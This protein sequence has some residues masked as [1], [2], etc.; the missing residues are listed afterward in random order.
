MRIEA[1]D[2]SRL[3]SGVL[4]GGTAFLRH[5]YK[6]GV[7][8]DKINSFKLFIMGYLDSLWSVGV[9]CSQGR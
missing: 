7:N 5:L 1:A 9:C 8:L 4:D 6:S 3:E 2:P